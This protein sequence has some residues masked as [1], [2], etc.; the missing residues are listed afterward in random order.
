[1]FT[2]QDNDFQEIN[3]EGFI[4]LNIS[5][6]VSHVFDNFQNLPTFLLLSMY[7]LSSLDILR[8]NP[9]VYIFN[10]NNIFG[11]LLGYVIFYKFIWNTLVFSSFS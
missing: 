4:R 7:N 1:M 11:K 8:G 5:I 3:L 6:V 2:D 10:K 9:S